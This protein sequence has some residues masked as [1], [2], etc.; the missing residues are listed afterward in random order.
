METELSDTGLRAWN[1]GLGE[2]LTD[3]D[4]FLVVPPSKGTL[5]T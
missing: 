1:D 4:G 2:R 5:R 3:V